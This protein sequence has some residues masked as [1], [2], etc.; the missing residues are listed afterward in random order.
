[1]SIKLIIPGPQRL[2]APMLS[3]FGGGSVRGFNP[4]GGVEFGWEIGLTI[5]L[6]TASNTGPLSPS[7][8][9]F[10]TAYSGQFWYD[11]GHWAKVNNFQT[12][13]SDF[14]LPGVYEFTM[15]GASGNDPAATGFTAGAGARINGRLTV[16]SRI[17]FNFIVGQ[18]GVKTGAGSDQSQ[19]GGGAS[20]FFTGS[21]ASGTSDAAAAGGGGGSLNGGTGSNA[22]ANITGLAYDSGA[23]L[24]DAGISTDY[25]V[26]G[27]GWNQDSPL[28]NPGGPGT[29]TQGKGITNN[30]STQAGNGFIYAGDGSSGGFGGGGGQVNS[31]SN[32]SGAGGGWTGGDGRNEPLPSRGGGS[33]FEG[34]NWSST[35]YVGTNS[36]N[37]SISIQRIS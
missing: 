32:R 25:S 12:I 23:T 15:N 35:S 34:S 6:S 29:E 10:N 16:S 18:R 30:N 17:Q 13:S 14:V 22:R 33:K 4:G 36:G 3:S 28:P 37:G 27:I 5:N 8:S 21:S 26:G 24:G 2:F 7:A 20:W 11:D 19:P 31:G 9:Q 1:M